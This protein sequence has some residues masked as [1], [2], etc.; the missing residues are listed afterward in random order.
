[1]TSMLSPGRVRRSIRTACAVGAAGLVVVAVSGCE[2]PKPV[3]TITVGSTSVHSHDMCDNDGKK[4]GNK[5]FEVCAAEAKSKSIDFTGSDT[6]RIGVEP[7]VAERGWEVLGTIQ[8]PQSGQEQ[9][10]KLVQFTKKTYATTEGL[11]LSLL[12]DKSEL[13]VVERDKEKGDPYGVW[14]FTLNK[15]DH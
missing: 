7:E 12:P 9:T 13:V 6:L 15:K 3:T 5:A 10:A 4:M 1:M 2:K 11:D 8:N 14:N